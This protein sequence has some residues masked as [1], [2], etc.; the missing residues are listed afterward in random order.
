MLNPSTTK[1]NKSRVKG[2]PCLSPQPNLEKGD[3]DL[4]IKKQKRQKKHMP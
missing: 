1:M 3:L 4:F 2:Q